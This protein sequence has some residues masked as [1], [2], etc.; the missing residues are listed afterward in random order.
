MNIAPYIPSNSCVRECE[1]Y[2]AYF[3]DSFPTESMR[4]FTHQCVPGGYALKRYMKLSPISIGIC[5]APGA[6][7]DHGVPCILDSTSDLPQKANVLKMM[8]LHEPMPMNACVEGHPVV[9]YNLSPP[10]SL[11]KLERLQSNVQPRC[12]HPHPISALVPEIGHSS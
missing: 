2:L 12:H 6:P 3:S 9:D 8:G 7:S 1:W 4:A 11:S 10:I 5:V